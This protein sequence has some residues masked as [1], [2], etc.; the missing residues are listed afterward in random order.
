MAKSRMASAVQCPG[1]VATPPASTVSP[2][3]TSTVTSKSAVGDVAASAKPD[4][5]G[6]RAQPTPGSQGRI[7]KNDPNR[8]ASPS[9][10][11]RS[12]T[13][14]GSVSV[15]DV[16]SVSVRLATS[17]PEWATSVVGSGWSTGTGLPSTPTG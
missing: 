6:S 12:S 1:P 11:T 9:R 8:T 14:F 5:G 3:G 13:G 16:V 4:V 15:H 2:A 7:G 17:G 10:E